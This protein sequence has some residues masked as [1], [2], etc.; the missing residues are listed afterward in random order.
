[1]NPAYQTLFYPFETGRLERP[2]AVQRIL[3]MNAAFCAGLAPFDKKSYLMQQYFRPGAA[4]LQAEGYAVQSTVP[5]EG[6]FDFIF[7]AAPKNITEVKYL[8]A[9]GAKILKEGGILLCSAA[10]DAGGGRLKKLLET[11]GFSGIQQES[12][13]RARAAWARKEVLNV[14]Y[15]EEWITDG[16]PQKILGG[17]FVSQPGI[18]GWDKIDKGSEIL[19][20]HL[21]VDLQGS[22]A[23]FGCGYGYL[24]DHVL[25]RNPGV[26][27]FFCIDADFRA[28]ECARQNLASFKNVRYFWEDLA[29]P[30]LNLS[31]LDFIVMNPPFHAGKAADP[32]LGQAF[33]AS[34]HAG[35]RAG[36]RLYMVA[37]ATLPYE[38]GLQKLYSSVQKKYEGEGFKIFEA[39]K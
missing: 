13:Y 25:S 36:G 34:A 26:H 16:S 33:I 6:A 10:N 4:Q 18:F 3:F 23:D 38:E 15:A 37:N 24:S 2:Q 22:G 11:L 32:A 7:L 17:R 29:Q 8:L 12:K 1:M 19:A 14:K 28:I 39:V 30:L 5:D 31:G 21:P 27:E 20:R 9:S 35:L